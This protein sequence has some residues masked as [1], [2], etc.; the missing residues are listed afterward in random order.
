M[1]KVL[2][3]LFHNWSEWKLYECDVCFGDCVVR[4]QRQ[5]RECKRCNMVE[6]RDLY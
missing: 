6:K 3:I 5:K 2:C 1:N 4:T